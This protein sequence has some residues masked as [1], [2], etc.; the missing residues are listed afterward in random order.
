MAL[1]HSVYYLFFL[2]LSP[3]STLCVFFYSILYN[4]DGVLSINPSDIAFVFGHFNIHHKDQLTY[5]CGTDRLVNFVITFLSRMTLFRW[6]TFLLRSMT[7]S[8]TVLLFWIYFYLLTLQWLSLH[9]E[10]LIM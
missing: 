3:F 5:S 10:I 7:V 4:I 9:W 8:L 1:P 6:L 2:Y